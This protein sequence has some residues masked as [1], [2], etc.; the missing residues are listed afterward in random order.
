MSLHRSDK[1]TLLHFSHF[2]HFTSLPIS[3]Y[4]LCA[5]VLEE[6]LGPDLK[7]LRVGVAV[8]NKSLQYRMGLTAKVEEVVDDDAKVSG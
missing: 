6:H 4:I 1:V 7:A 3:H 8:T 2:S 5:A